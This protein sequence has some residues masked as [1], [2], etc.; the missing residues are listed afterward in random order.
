MVNTTSHNYAGFYKADSQSEALQRLCLQ[1]LP[2]ADAEAVPLLESAAHD[3]LAKF[4][5]ADFCY[6]TSTEYGSNYVA[7]PALMNDAKTVVIADK[8]CHNSMFSGMYLAQ[9]GH[10]RLLKFA[11]NDAEDLERC[12]QEVDGR[13]DQVMVAV[14]GLY[15]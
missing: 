15:R 1:K 10:S 12:L 7:F 2:L 5:E 13:Y 11:H 6:T 9:P 14:E 4:M 3:A 8:N